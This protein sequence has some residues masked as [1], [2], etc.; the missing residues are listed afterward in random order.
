MQT[1]VYSNAVTLNA[2]AGETEADKGRGIIKFT[3]P[4]DGYVFMKWSV[5]GNEGK[6]GGTYM[7]QT[8][9]IQKEN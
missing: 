2:S 9:T 8:M 7:P 3:M 6:G 4:K 5:A 1:S